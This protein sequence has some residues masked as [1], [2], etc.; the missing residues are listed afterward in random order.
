[1]LRTTPLWFTER[2][3]ARMEEDW[4]VWLDANLPEDED[5]WDAFIDDNYETF[6]ERWMEDN[7]PDSPY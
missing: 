7:A 5:D 6:V 4:S 1:M 2:D 3:S